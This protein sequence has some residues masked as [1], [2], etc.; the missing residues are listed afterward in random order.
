MSP[1]LGEGDIIS[2]YRQSQTGL[3]TTNVIG[4]TYYE[5]MILLNYVVH[6]PGRLV[7]AFFQQPFILLQLTESTNAG[8]ILVAMTSRLFWVLST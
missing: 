1:F 5:A 3:G 2:N 6:L 7:F 4:P 8:R